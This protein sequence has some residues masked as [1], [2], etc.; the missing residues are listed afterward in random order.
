MTVRLWDVESGRELRKF[1]G[2]Q[3]HVGEVRFTPDGRQ[4]LSGGSDQTMRF[5]DLEQR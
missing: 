2:H 4:I 5:W 1:E 3:S